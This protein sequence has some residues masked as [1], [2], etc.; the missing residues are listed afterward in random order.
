MV[1]VAPLPVDVGVNEVMVGAGMK[2]K[3]PSATVPPGVVTETLPEAPAATTAVI[4]V[5][6]T[7]V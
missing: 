5:D 1:T 2:T 7:T 6:D 3:P 4:L